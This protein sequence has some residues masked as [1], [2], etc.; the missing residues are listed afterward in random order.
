MKRNLSILFLLLSI[1]IRL[2]AQNSTGDNGSQPVGMDYL[3]TSKKPSLHRSP[4][5]IPLYVTFTKE[6][7]TIDISYDGEDDGEVYLYLGEDIVGYDSQINTTLQVPTNKGMYTIEIV[8][9]S[10]TACGSFQLQ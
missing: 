6:T 1:T 10:W 3:Y 4:I 9:S 8:T 5:Q 7:N 2:I